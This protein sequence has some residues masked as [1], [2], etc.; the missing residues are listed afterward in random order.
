MVAAS[1]RSS[2]SSP[3]P[4]MWAVSSS[5]PPQAPRPSPRPTVTIDIT[6]MNRAAR[7]S[8]RLR[9]ADP[10]EDVVD[11]RDPD[12][13]LRLRVVEELLDRLLPLARA[14]RARGVR[15]PRVDVVGG[16]GAEH[17]RRAVAVVVL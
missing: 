11:R 10:V 4:S 2:S 5:S 9:V 3:P 6:D 12:A 8:E 1:T 14:R 16:V 7:I 15:A 13:R 17:D